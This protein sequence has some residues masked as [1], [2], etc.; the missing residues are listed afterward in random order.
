MSLSNIHIR[1]GKWSKFWST[2]HSAIIMLNPQP[3]FVL[4]LEAVIAPVS[5]SQTYFRMMTMILHS[6]ISFDF[7]RNPAIVA[8]SATSVHHSR[9]MKVH[10]I[11]C[12]LELLWQSYRFSKL[13][14]VIEKR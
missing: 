12:K 9:R 4:I 11:L 3:Y 5:Q 2:H 8:Q 13:I 14:F 7:D 1:H 6:A 10:S